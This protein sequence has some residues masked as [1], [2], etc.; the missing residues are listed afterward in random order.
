M[1][2]RFIC[3][4]LILPVSITTIE[5]T[6]STI[7]IMKTIVI[8]KSFMQTTYLFTSKKTL[9]IYLVNNQLWI[10]T[11]FLNHILSKVSK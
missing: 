6:I 4:G 9:L 11:G 10:K 1:I 3:I 7:K 5:K 2:D 8:D